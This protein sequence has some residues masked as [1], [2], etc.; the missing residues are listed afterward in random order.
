MIEAGL[1]DLATGSIASYCSV[2]PEQVGSLSVEAIH[3][4]DRRIYRLVPS[5]PGSAFVLKVRGASAEKPD[6]LSENAS[7]VEYERIKAAYAIVRKSSGAITMPVPVAVYPGYQAILTTW[8]GGQELRRSYYRQAW[9]WP[10]A[11]A[12]LRTCF[13][14]CGEWLGRFHDLSRRTVATVPAME[15]RLRHLDRMIDEIGSSGRGRLGPAKLEHLRTVIRTGLTRPEHTLFGRLHGNYTLRNIL[16]SDAGAVPVDFEDSREDTIFMDTGQLVADVLLSSY[17]LYIMPGFR[18]R[19][20]REFIAAYGRHV[21]IDVEQVG[22][23]ALYHVL[24]A[25]YEI[26]TR[27]ERR[28]RPS[29]LASHQARIFEGLLTR[30]AQVVEKYI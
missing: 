2:S 12:E 25:Y 30:P 9:R 5:L 16:V 11:S 13:R 29:L 20:A 18:Q 6:D 21:P 14:K 3:D 15:N 8:C 23:F 24:A 27:E 22:S 19:L 10:A 1:K 7:I 26:L 4:A 28:K 17:R